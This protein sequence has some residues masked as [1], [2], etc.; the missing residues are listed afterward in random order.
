MPLHMTGALGTYTAALWSAASE[1]NATAAVTRDAQAFLT[2]AKEP[3][4]A[5]FLSN[6]FVAKSERSKAL[7]PLTAKLGFHDVSKSFLNVLISANR[8]SGAPD[9]F[10][11]FLD[12]AKAADG[13]IE[14]T[15][16]TAHV[17]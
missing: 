4:V 2:A 17:R 5:R 12:C 15:L 7:A 10:Q 8:L 13:K 3:A 1:K 6:P 16:T 14:G 9:V 11:A